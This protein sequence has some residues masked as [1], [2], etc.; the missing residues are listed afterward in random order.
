MSLMKVRVEEVSQSKLH[1][2]AS[3]SNRGFSMKAYQLIPNSWKPRSEY[4]VTLGY[5]IT[6][7]KL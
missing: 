2:S 4:M 5:F 3:I 6:L 1:M 7:E